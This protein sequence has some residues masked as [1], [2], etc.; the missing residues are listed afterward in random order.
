MVA[1]RSE[2]WNSPTP[3]GAKGKPRSSAASAAIARLGASGQK[4]FDR[5]SAIIGALFESTSG[6]TAPE[7][8]DLVRASG[9]SVSLATVQLTLRKLLEHGLANVERRAGALARFSATRGGPDDGRLVCIRCQSATPFTDPRVAT[10]HGEIGR[11]RGYVVQN[12]RLEIYGTCDR[13][14]VARAR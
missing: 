12:H 3:E 8:R 4:T 9:R 1:K 6:L 14:Q 13:C 5:R 10:L 2:P 11:V 7:L